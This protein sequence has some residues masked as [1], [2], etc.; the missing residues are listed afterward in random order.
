[1][2][3]LEKMR[4]TLENAATQFSEKM[5]QSKREC[6]GDC[7]KIFH[8]S[9]SLRWS[10]N[11]PHD[12]ATE[13]YTV[14]AF[15]ALFTYQRHLFT[16]QNIIYVC[17]GVFVERLWSH[18]LSLICI[19][20][21]W[22]IPFPMQGQSS[23]ISFSWT[24]PLNSSKSCRHFFCEKLRIVFIKWR[25]CMFFGNKSSIW[26]KPPLCSSYDSAWMRGPLTSSYLSFLENTKCI[27]M[28]PRQFCP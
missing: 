5:S 6:S 12:L 2:Y 21:A 3:T 4:K 11:E 23:L 20:T 24:L 16:E 19:E 9:I 14:W 15:N 17:E 8:K 10:H 28:G 7:L 25:S 26:A 27:H 1:M 13:V 22:F 18:R